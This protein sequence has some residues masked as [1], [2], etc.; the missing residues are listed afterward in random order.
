MNQN[1]PLLSYLIRANLSLRFHRSTFFRSGAEHPLGFQ[2]DLAAR[3]IADN[4]FDIA[5]RQH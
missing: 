2:P 1:T 3:L 5:G 4:E